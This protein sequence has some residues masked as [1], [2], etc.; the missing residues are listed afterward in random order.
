MK[1]SYSDGD[2]DHGRYGTEDD[3]NSENDLMDEDDYDE[4][5]GHHIG[6]FGNNFDPKK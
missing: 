1:S 6:T 5:M 4:D 2:L 3:Y